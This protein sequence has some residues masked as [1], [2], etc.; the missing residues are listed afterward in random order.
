MKRRAAAGV[1][2]ERVRAGA[3]GAPACGILHSASR[4]RT[5]GKWFRAC[6]DSN[7]SITPAQA[8][9]RSEVERV[10]TARYRVRL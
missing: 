8:M 9:F 7:Q 4:T 6:F 5:D 1:P 2:P 10:L 3:A